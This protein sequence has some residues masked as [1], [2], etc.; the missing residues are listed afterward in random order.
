MEAVLKN[1]ID[2]LKS[3]PGKIDWN[4]SNP[5]Q[6]ASRLI[7]EKSSKFI[8][9]TQATWETQLTPG[10]KHRDTRA[11]IEVPLDQA[12]AWWITGKMTHGNPFHT[13]VWIVD[14]VLVQRDVAGKIQWWVADAASGAPVSETD[15]QFFGYRIIEHDRKLPLGRRM[16]V[17]WREF[18]R[19]TDAEGK[20]LLKPGDWDPKYQWLA[21]ARSKDRSPAFFGFQDYNAQN[22]S[23]QNGN[24]DLSYGIPRLAARQPLLFQPLGKGGLPS[25]GVGAVL[26]NATATQTAGAGY[27]QVFPTEQGTPGASS[28]LNFTAG[29]TIPNAVITATGSQGRTSVYASQDSH[30]IL[31]VAGYFTAGT[32]TGGTGSGPA[33]SGLVVAAP[34]TSVAYDR[35]AWSA[36]IDADRDCQDTRAE[37]LLAETAV[38]PV[39]SADGCAVITGRWV[40]PY[41]G[42]TWTQASDVDIDHTVPL[43]NAHRSGGWAWDAGK[44]AQFANDLGNP[45]HLIAIEDGLN[46]AKGDKSPDQWQPPLADSRCGYANNWISIKK[47]WSLTVTQAE[48]D[49]LAGMLATCG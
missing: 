11:E 9:K 37:V 48:Y 38:T 36:W 42:L 28:N 14:S 21:I 35:N 29:Q 16:D 1:T 10:D 12:G 6:I 43:A 4:R 40:D 30:L 47:R 18:Q 24:R 34:N 31:D 2:Y 41:T 8:G 13:L 46:A 33:L 20:T 49:A 26:Y 32:S 45:E 22:P 7:Q 23:W 27:L 5:S 39:L 15:L 19:A 17:K 3:N 25:S 44:K